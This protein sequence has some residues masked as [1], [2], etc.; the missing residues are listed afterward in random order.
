MSYGIELNPVQIVDIVND[1]KK[2]NNKSMLY[3]SKSLK[4]CEEFW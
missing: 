2:V 4:V 3:Y 1:A